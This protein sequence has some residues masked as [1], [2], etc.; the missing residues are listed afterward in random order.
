[1][2]QDQV[3]DRVATKPRHR[4]RSI[5]RQ[6]LVTINVV[7]VLALTILLVVDYPLTSKNTYASAGHETCYCMSPDG[8]TVELTSTGMVLGVESP[9]FAEKQRPLAVRRRFIRKEVQC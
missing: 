1:M 2:I 4:P 3:P 9:P 6:L 5:R 7:L 8:T